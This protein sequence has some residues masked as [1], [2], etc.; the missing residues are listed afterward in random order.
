MIRKNV[1]ANRK[2]LA[3]FGL[4]LFILAMAQTVI[5]A[6]ISVTPT[7][8][9]LQIPKGQSYTDAIRVVNVGKLDVMVKVYLSDFDFQANGN[10]RFPDA[11]TGK[12]SLADYVRLN[13]TSLQLEPGEEKFVRFTLT[14]PDNLAG[15]YQGILFFQ[16][17]PKGIKTPAPGKQVM[18]ST[19]I[20]AAI[21]AAVKNTAIPSS[22]ISDIFF[23]QAQTPG[24]SSFHYAL[25]Y[26]NNGN[27]H[28]RPTG[29]L[30][31]LDAAGKEVAS[32]PVN[33][34]K[35][36]VLRDSFRIFAGDFK[37]KS[38]LRDGSYKV[39]SEID[40]GKEI[41][42]A[43]K[44][45][46]LLNTGGIESFTA[47]LS[48]PAKDNDAVKI[49]FSSVTKGIEPGKDNQHRQKV[50]RIKSITGELQG[51][52]LANIP[53]K[54]PQGKTPQTLE[55][56]GEWSGT[57]KPGMYIAEFLIFL[58]ENVALTSFCLIDNTG[59]R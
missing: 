19:R 37:N 6:S 14:M 24:N 13:P 3:C 53:V 44:P 25:L 23:S 42:V 50:F 45:V 54:V 47:K 59:G 31:I 29:K 20:G 10:I 48:V 8:Y 5:H 28:L 11:G 22:E 55:Y 40:Y 16:T 9:E 36:S 21:Y 46:Y 56:T 43:E 15:E 38:E 32:T 39:V 52:L 34:N 7:I 57:L 12:Y 1:K 2:I 17:L 4:F 35:T 18:V 49:V 41:L 33:E 51:E 26:H 58:Q 27:I 30:K